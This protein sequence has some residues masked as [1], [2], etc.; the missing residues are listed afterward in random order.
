MRTD[1]KLAIVQLIHVAAWSSYYT[2][3]REVYS[4][5][6]GYLLLLAAAETMPTLA[7]LV[8]GVL[9]ERYGY[10]LVFLLGLAEG[11]G[12]ASA[13]L[14]LYNE[15][16]LLASVAVASLSWSISGPQIYAYTLT[17]SGQSGESLGV[18]TAGSTLGWTLGSLAPI[19]A[20]ETGPR[21]ILVAAGASTA[22]AYLSIL[23]LEGPSKPVARRRHYSGRGA[24]LPILVLAALSYTGVEIIGSIYMGKLSREA[25]VHLYSLANMASGLI[26]ALVRPLAGRIVDARGPSSILAV[27]LAAYTLYLTCLDVARGP[28]M[29]LAWVI[30]LYPFFELS[31]YKLSSA[32]LG[33]ALGVAA[34]SA[35][36]GITGSILAF[37]GLAGLGEK[38]LFYIALASF[39]S[40]SIMALAVGG[41]REGGTGG[42][43]WRETSNEA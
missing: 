41:W 13:G 5:D 1:A 11:I 36:Y 24:V 35:S 38:S 2:L 42:T 30:P 20:L 10:R 26:S 34:V 4:G 6:P 32:I 27:A 15:K 9:A 7:G 21:T 16:L 33:E 28:L 18:V 39:L 23:S 31:L 19:V 29:A 12:L 14:F 40:A 3:T 8:G 43:G 22:I 37:S 25:G 17:Y